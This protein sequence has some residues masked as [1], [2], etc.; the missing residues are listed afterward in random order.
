MIGT[1]VYATSFLGFLVI[2]A[3]SDVADLR[4]PNRLTLAMAMGGL[5]AVW[6]LGAGASALPSAALT[7]AATLAV[8]WA[9]FELGWLG[10]GDAKLAAAASLWL[11]PEA[12]LVFVLATAVFGALLAA[13]LIVLSR[14]ELALSTVGS[15]WRSR[16]TADAISVPYAL[17]MAPAGGVAMLACFPDLL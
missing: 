2:A 13:V 7:G 6:L 1:W 10:G 12:M 4:I 15:R 9:M 8:T 5:P 17:A 14:W 3:L 11:G 16:L